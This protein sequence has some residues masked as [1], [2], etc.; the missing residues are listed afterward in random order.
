[1]NEELKQQLRQEILAEL[2]EE[3]QT[4]TE[5]REQVRTEVEAELR[6]EMERR[7]KLA[8]FAAEI[9]GGEA[10][11]STDPAELVAL[12]AGMDEGALAKLQDVL[13]A[14]VV[15]FSEAGSSREGRGDAKALPAELREQLQIWV[16]AG[17]HIEE[18]FSLNADAVDAQMDE[19]D[20]SEFGEGGES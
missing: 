13:Q 9:C 15:D 3:Q 6:E 4:R 16:D 18:F 12:M 5:L 20:L 17:Q 10:G 11:L 2:E 1:M 7:G 14:K 19:Y 8:E